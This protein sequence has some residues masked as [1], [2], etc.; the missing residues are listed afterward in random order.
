M[1]ISINLHYKFNLNYIQAFISNEIQIMSFPSVKLSHRFRIKYSYYMLPCQVLHDLV[2][3]SSLT[4][5]PTTLIPTH[6][7]QPSPCPSLYPRAFALVFLLVLAT[8]FICTCF[9]LITKPSV[10]TDFPRHF[11]LPSYYMYFPSHSY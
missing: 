4:S 6:C 1:V 10:Q 9:L 3:P 8:L 5:L 7:H 2:L 11:P